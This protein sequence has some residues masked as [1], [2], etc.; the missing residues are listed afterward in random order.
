MPEKEGRKERRQ[1]E[2]LKVIRLRALRPTSIHINIE[3]SKR[4]RPATP[5]HSYLVKIMVKEPTAVATYL[6]NV[7]VFLPSLSLSLSVSIRHV[8]HFRTRQNE[9]NAHTVFNYLITRNVHC[10]ALYTSQLAGQLEDMVL[11]QC[12]S[13]SSLPT[14]N[15][16]L[17]LATTFSV[18]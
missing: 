12:M 17:E 10:S 11:R 18:E 15:L 6:F 4:P 2:E 1:K 14:D 13:R 16:N 3:K 9:S 7:F 8:F 5:T